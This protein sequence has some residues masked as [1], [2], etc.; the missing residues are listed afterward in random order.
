M[1]NQQNDNY[2]EM[3]QEQ[4]KNDKPSIATD[5]DNHSGDSNFEPEQ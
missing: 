4:L 3:K 5:K 1:S 2:E